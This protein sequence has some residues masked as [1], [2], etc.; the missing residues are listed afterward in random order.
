MENHYWF[1]CNLGDIL[2]TKLLDL[3]KIYDKNKADERPMNEFIKL[4]VNTVY[5]DI[6]SPYFYIGNTIT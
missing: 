4:V 1:S 5:G 2:I 6:V 3:R